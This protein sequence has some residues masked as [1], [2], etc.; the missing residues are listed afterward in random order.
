[1]LGEANGMTHMTSFVDEAGANHILSS[2]G[3]FQYMHANVR[4]SGAI[5]LSNFTGQV[6]D[7][8]EY[9][10]LWLINFR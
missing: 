6:G 5:N 10:L 1:M 3:R 9:D 4:E 2:S 8:V 7:E